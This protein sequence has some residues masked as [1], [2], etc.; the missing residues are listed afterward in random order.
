MIVTWR[1]IFHARLYTRVLYQNPLLIMRLVIHIHIHSVTLENKTIAKIEKYSGTIS[2]L[3]KVYI[4]NTK[5][6][7]QT[8]RPIMDNSC[9]KALECA[10]AQKEKK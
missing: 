4:Y 3:P 8:R 6:A 10:R 1:A 2:S 9:T 5:R 7:G